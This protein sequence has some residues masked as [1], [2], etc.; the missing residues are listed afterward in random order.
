MEKYKTTADCKCGKEFVVRFEAG[1]TYSYFT[2][3]KECPECGAE[4]EIHC[5]PGMF[6]KQIQVKVK[7]LKHTAKMLEILGISDDGS[8]AS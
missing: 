4:L 8:T 2:T 5:K 7:L 3:R 1:A 6:R